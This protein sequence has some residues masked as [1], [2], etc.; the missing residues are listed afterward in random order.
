M[1]TGKNL[2]KEIEILLVED[3]PSDAELTRMALRHG[4][5]KNVLHHVVDGVEALEFLR[6]E[7]EYAD[8]P[9][10]DI[11]LLDLNLPRKN[12]R[13]LLAD[14]QASDDWRSIPVIVLTSSDNESDVEAV[15]SLN[16]NSYIKKPVD[17]PQFNEAMR[18]F[19][20]FWLSWV[21]LPGSRSRTR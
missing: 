21:V 7:G 11:I 17:L 18:S 20:S 15:Y 19:D 1:P 5:V 6:K 3:S 4:R 12:G 13:E 9:R 8:A 10:P 14:L 16:A 2:G